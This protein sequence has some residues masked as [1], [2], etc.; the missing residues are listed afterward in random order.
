M[1]SEYFLSAK[2][3]GVLSTADTQGKV[4]AAV[5]ARPHFID[6]K[7]VAFIMA[8]KHSH[9]NVRENPH[10]VYLFKEDGPQYQ[11]KRLFLTRIGESEDK[12]LI[13]NLRRSKHCWPVSKECDSERRFLVQFRVDSVKPLIGDGSV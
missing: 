6:E 13:E 8:D 9:R 5:Y 3:M 12:A 11:G 10:A 2:G 4:D 1:L 7:T